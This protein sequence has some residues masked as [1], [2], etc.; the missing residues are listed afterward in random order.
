MELDA[1]EGGA[2]ADA[3]VQQLRIVY[4][5]DH[6]GTH[7]DVGHSGIPTSVAVHTAHR[8]GVG[9]CHCAAEFSVS[10]V[11]IG[12]IGGGR[13]SVGLCTVSRQHGDTALTNRR[14][15]HL[16][17]GNRVVTQSQI[18]GICITTHAVDHLHAV[19]A[20]G[21][22]VL[23]FR[24][25]R[26]TVVNGIV[27]A[28]PDVGKIFHRAGRQS[29]GPLTRTDVQRKVAAVQLHFRKRILA[30]CSHFA[31][32]T[33]VTV[34]N[35]HRVVTGNTHFNTVRVGIARHI[36]A[37]MQSLP[38]RSHQNRAILARTDAPAIVHRR[39]GHN[40]QSIHG[41]LVCA[42]RRTACAVVRHG[43]GNVLEAL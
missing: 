28:H 25:K 27:V 20:R 36:P 21:S 18:I 42:C 35:R 29:G 26:R 17:L 39:D 12:E 33:A 15:V 14:V 1:V 22:D 19:G 34:R 4:Q 43:H 5:E 31:A 37:V 8:V 13:P 41:H 7:R 30:H 2:R 24:H 6:I 11:D 3:L 23:I 38:C 10:V 16:H 9:A 32:P 40:R